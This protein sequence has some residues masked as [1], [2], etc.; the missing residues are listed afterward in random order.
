MNKLKTYF[1][2][3]LL[4]FLALFSL[5]V[6][7]Q[8]ISLYNNLS[9]IHPALGLVAV[10]LA[11]ILLFVLIFF[12][13]FVIFKY[14][15]VKKLGKNPSREEIEKFK[16]ERIARLEKNKSLKQLGYSFEN[17]SQDQIL[18][19]T[20]QL[21]K[22][23]AMEVT[24]KNANS[25]FL[26]TAVSQNGA[27]D[28]LSVLFSLGLMVY[29]IIEIYENRPDLKRVIYLY[30]QIAS[31]VLVAG[32]IEDLDLIEEQIEPLLTSLLS[33]SIFA[34]IPGAISI[35]NI[36]SNSLVE[37]S[38][39]AL[40]TLRVGIVTT[41][42]LSSSI[43]MDKKSLRKGAF[44]EATGLLGSIIVNNS[45]KVIKSITKATKKAT[46]DKIKN[47]FNKFKDLEEV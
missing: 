46:I 31:V 15:K 35:A 22:E 10:V 29:Q 21:L 14:P 34:A 32:S 23:K 19:E 6:L 12:Q 3:S 47:P 36:V 4:L 9:Q 25:I 41:R 1:I 20:D 8:T 2:G 28:S 30:S 18:E 27:L 38:V 26:T 40:L 5:I 45:Y 39:N 11:L 33:S 43:E 37:G 44:L 16:N 13:V 42:Y 17:K 24:K 7:N